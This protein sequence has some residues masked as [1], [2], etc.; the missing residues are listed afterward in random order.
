MS[1]SKLVR[2][3][4][5]YKES[6]LSALS[7]YHEEGRYSY[8]NALQLKSNFDAYIEELRIERGHPHQPLQE[9]ADPVPETVLWY[10]KN[11]S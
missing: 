8:K 9:W 10:V 1:A 6:F 4:A 5:E 11:E 7:E 3:S 2:P